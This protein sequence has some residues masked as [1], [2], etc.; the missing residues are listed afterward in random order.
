MLM[1]KRLV[2]GKDLQCP[3]Q[4]MA[5][6][7]RSA[8]HGMATI[9]MILITQ[10]FTFWNNDRDIPLKRDINSTPP[11]QLKAQIDYVRY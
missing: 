3:C 1:D 11:E 8:L 9:A 4:G 10:G 7:W 6:R 5:I 2:I